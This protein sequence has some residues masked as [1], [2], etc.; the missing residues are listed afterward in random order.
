MVG[1]KIR[2]QFHQISQIA[3]FEVSSPRPCEF[4][5]RGRFHDPKSNGVS[6]FILILVVRAAAGRSVGFGRCE[7]L[8][9]EAIDQDLLRLP[10][11]FDAVSPLGDVAP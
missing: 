5:D 2:G 8:V 1:R 9:D 6:L 10:T 11:G 4:A 3:G 7:A